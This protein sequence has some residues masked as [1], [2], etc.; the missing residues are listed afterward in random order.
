MIMNQFGKYFTTEDAL[1]LGVV[2]AN[3]PDTRTVEGAVQHIAAIEQ[4]IGKT[5]DALIN[6][7]HLLRETTAQT[8]IQG[9]A[10]V[11]QVAQACNKKLWADCYPEEL[12]QKKQLTP[13][14]ESGSTL[15]PLG[16]YMRPTWLDK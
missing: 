10:F 8:V 9:H 1:L 4:S 7:S 16:L 13:L 12:V 2:N 3:R 15:L 5:L 11:Q 14:L 6:N